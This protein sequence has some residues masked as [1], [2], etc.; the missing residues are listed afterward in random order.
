MYHHCN[1]WSRRY[2]YA[3]AHAEKRA[4]Q[5]F[6]ESRQHRHG[7]FGVRRPLRYLSYQLDL[8]ERQRR[9]IAAALD[10]LKIERE[11]GKLDKK[12]TVSALAEL[13]TRDDVSVDELR[14]ALSPRVASTENLQI[15]IA[16]AVQEIA[17]VLDPDQREEFAHLLRSG[18]L[19]L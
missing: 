14:R 15:V 19:D 10:R 9:H 16:T 8:D 3:S 17:S 6:F 4:E 2:A 1:R 11:Q 5:P 18:V 13:V 12:K 7:G